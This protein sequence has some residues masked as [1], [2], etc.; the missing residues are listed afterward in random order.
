LREELEIIASYEVLERGSSA[1][2]LG[3]WDKGGIKEVA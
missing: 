1:E 2:D 3:S